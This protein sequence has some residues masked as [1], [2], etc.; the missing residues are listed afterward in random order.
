MFERSGPK[1]GPRN[2]SRRQLLAAG[3]GLGAAGLLLEA[4][5]APPRATARS[6]AAALSHLVWVWQ[7]STDDEPNRIGARLRDHGL[8][9]LLKTHDGLDWM[10]EYDRSRYAVSGPT[11]AA[12]LAGF[13]ED[14]GVPFHAWCVVRGINP[15]R[16][17]GMA[18]DVLAA[19]ARSLYLDVEPHSGFWQGTAADARAFGNELRRLQPDA[20]V[21]LSIDP[22]PWMLERLP[23]GEF[24]AFT[25]EI[26]PQ[27]Y[28][29]SF[30]TSANHRRYADSGY[31]L[32]PEGVTPAFL[33]EVTAATLDGFGL[34]ITYVG[35]GASP[36]SDDWQQFMDAALGGGSAIVSAWRYGVTTDEVFAILRDRPPVLPAPAVYVVQAGDTLFAIAAAHGVSAAEIIALNGIADPDYLFV[37]QELLLAGGVPPGP[38]QE[39]ARPAGPTQTYVVEAGDTLLAIALRFSTNVDTLVQLNGLADPDYVFVGQALVVPS[40]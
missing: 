21:V 4:A 17:A 40:V 8:G 3:L 32:G 34:P 31:P 24:A 30:D 23:L 12:V 26:A 19:G 16:E 6:R 13:Y 39:A 5:A 14:G 2:L 7:F 9:I 25:N 20:H 11:Q 35:Q 29:R 28:W 18:A 36:D 1:P 37:G 15:L 33:I 38:V 22:R 27:L 10:A